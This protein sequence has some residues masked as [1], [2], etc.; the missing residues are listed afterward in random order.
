MRA[1]NMMKFLESRKFD[2]LVVIGLVLLLIFI[3]FVFPVSATNYTVNC[4]GGLK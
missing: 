1:G 3:I 2:V 4:N